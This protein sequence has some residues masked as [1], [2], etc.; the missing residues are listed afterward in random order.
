[1]A[2][3]MD[4]PAVPTLDIDKHIAYVQNRVREVTAA[5]VAAPGGIDL[6]TLAVDLSGVEALNS[7]YV[8]S[9]DE[10]AGF[11]DSLFGALGL[12]SVD[13][14]LDGGGEAHRDD[15]QDSSAVGGMDAPTDAAQELDADGIDGID[16]SEL[17]LSGSLDENDD[18]LGDLE[19]MAADFVID[20]D[21]D[22]DD[23]SFD[24]S[25]LDEPGKAKPTKAVAIDLS[26][27]DLDEPGQAK[28]TKSVAIDLSVL[29][30]ESEDK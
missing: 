18:E 11:V 21:G 29:D 14:E 23:Y 20:V 26:A 30:V 19:D 6:S 22:A 1:M 5:D 24:P 2:R 3:L 12:P 15:E 17:F 4:A 10:V 16:G 13:D 8:A 7:E 25:Q 28:P 27:L 9:A